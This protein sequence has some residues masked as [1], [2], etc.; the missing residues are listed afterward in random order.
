MGSSEAE[1]HAEFMVENFALGSA[2]GNSTV[3]KSARITEISLGIIGNLACH[4]TAME[5]DHFYGW[6]DWS[7]I[8]TVVSR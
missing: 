7:S 4:D 5:K 6:S 3:S 2:F 8:A 1:T